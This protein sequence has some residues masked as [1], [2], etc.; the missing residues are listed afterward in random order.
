MQKQRNRRAEGK[1]ENSP[2]KSQRSKG[3]RLGGERRKGNEPRKLAPCEL[4]TLVDVEE[5]AKGGGHTQ[6]KD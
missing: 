1:L 4:K 3:W 6:S 2:R 5:I